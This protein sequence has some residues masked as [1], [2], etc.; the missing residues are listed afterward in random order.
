MCSSG[1][2]AYK[3]PCSDTDM[4]GVAGIVLQNF[5][6]KIMFFTIHFVNDWHIVL[7]LLIRFMTAKEYI[8]FCKTKFSCT[9]LCSLAVLQHY[10]AF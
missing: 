6:I 2:V 1:N 10:N 4:T 9:F 8:A 7:H 5:T 3:L